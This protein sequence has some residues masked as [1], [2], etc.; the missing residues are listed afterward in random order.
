VNNKISLMWISLLTFI[1]SVSAAQQTVDI[2]RVITNFF[3]KPVSL[4]MLE[5]VPLWMVF[6]IFGLL[7]GP[8]FMSADKVFKDNKWVA[9]IVSFT[10]SAIVVFGT[11]FANWVLNLF[12]VSWILFWLLFVVA[13]IGEV[14]FWFA[15]IHKRTAEALSSIEGA[16][17][18]WKKDRLYYKKERKQVEREL[19]DLDEVIKKVKDAKKHKD[20]ADFDGMVSDAISHL[21]HVKDEIIRS[22]KLENRRF[23][24]EKEGAVEEL[25]D[26][27]RKVRADIEEALNDLYNKRPD[28]AESNLERAKKKLKRWKKYSKR[29]LKEGKQ[30]L[31]EAEENFGREEEDNQEQQEPAESNISELIKDYVD[32][33]EREVDGFL[34][35]EGGINEG[36]VKARKKQLIDGLKKEFSSRNMAFDESNIWNEYFR[37]KEEEFE[38]ALQSNVKLL[39]SGQEK[40]EELEEEITKQGRRLRKYIDTGSQDISDMM[41]HITSDYQAFINYLSRKG[42][43]KDDLEKIWVERLAPIYTEYIVNEYNA[44]M[45]KLNAYGP[46]PAK[47]TEGY[48]EWK[49]LYDR[50]QLLRPYV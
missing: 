16:H 3:T 5:Q 34:K 47:G 6:L 4:I 9:I 30:D 45:A 15:K 42:F 2:G 35:G 13:T 33:W 28:S 26:L 20:T 40:E 8:L 12:S 25:K 44:V 19:D 37:P 32:A 50:A 23:K 17:A 43:T 49:W 1:S 39:G 48:K 46:I 36:H 27:A 31:R 38:R 14:I 22:I 7:F 29:L 10:I 24:A 18:E 41:K 21:E 11:P